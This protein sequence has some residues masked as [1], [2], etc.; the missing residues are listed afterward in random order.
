MTPFPP[1][2]E[3]VHIAQRR[4][5]YDEQAYEALHRDLPVPER[6]RRAVLRRRI[7]FLAGRWCAQEA[8]R[9][10]GVA[11]QAPLSIGEHGS[12]VWPSGMVGSIS[13]GQGW[14]MAAVASVDHVRA[15]GLDIEEK[16]SAE[17][18][19]AIHREIARDDEIALLD[20]RCIDRETGLTAIFSAK[21]SLF[22]ALYPQVR[23]YFDF[24]DAALEDI[25]TGSSML[26]LRLLKTLSDEHREHASYPVRFDW[27]GNRVLTRCIL[28]A[29]R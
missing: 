14:A 8:L 6:L 2:G 21:E 11:T 18:T 5:A 20:E 10:A 25:D 28:R 12:P 15:L 4:Y 16:L 3:H 27:S 9:D 1:F 22:K 19:G 13:H 23:C 29:H 26:S 7:D 17:V 24:R